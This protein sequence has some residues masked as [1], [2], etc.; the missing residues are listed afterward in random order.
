MISK[1]KKRS[2]LG[3][4]LYFPCFCPKIMLFSKKKKRGLHFES[5]FFFCIFFSNLCHSLKQKKKS[6]FFE[7]SSNLSIFVPK[8]SDLPIT[9][10]II[11]IFSKS[12]VALL[13]F[14]KFCSTKH[15]KCHFVLQPQ[16][17]FR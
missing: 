3:I 13:G 9:C 16:N 1:K 15:P 14:S 6:L 2:S 12:S 11:I 7:S 4:N 5:I 10:A 17:Y 8:F